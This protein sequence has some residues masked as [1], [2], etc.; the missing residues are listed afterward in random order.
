MRMDFSRRVE[1]SEE[2]EIEEKELFFDLDFYDRGCK[3]GWGYNEYSDEFYEMKSEVDKLKEENV[4]MLNITCNIVETLFQ[5]R[6]RKLQRFCHPKFLLE[7]HIRFAHQ[8][9]I[10]CHVLSFSKVQIGQVPKFDRHD[11]PDVSH[12][13]QALYYGEGITII[14]PFNSND[15]PNLLKKCLEDADGFVLDASQ[16]NMKCFVWFNGRNETEMELKDV[17]TLMKKLKVGE[18]HKRE[19][20]PYAKCRKV[21]GSWNPP[22]IEGADCLSNFLTGLFACCQKLEIKL[23]KKSS[24]AALGVFNPE[25]LVEVASQLANAKKSFE[26]ADKTNYGELYRV[27]KRLFFAYQVYLRFMFKNKLKIDEGRFLPEFD[28]NK[29]SEDLIEW[30]PLEVRGKWDSCVEKADSSSVSADVVKL[31]AKFFIIPD[32]K[33]GVAF[34]DDDVGDA[35]ASSVI[36]PNLLNQADK[37]PFGFVNMKDAVSSEGIQGSILKMQCPRKC[38]PTLQV[39][40]CEKCGQF[41]HISSNCGGSVLLC[42]CGKKDYDK[43][44]FNCLTRKHIKYEIRGSPQSNGNSGQ[45]QFKSNSTI[46]ESDASGQSSGDDFEMIRKS[47]EEIPSSENVEGETTEKSDESSSAIW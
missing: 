42:G 3:I 15:N 39:W 44:L 36:T 34:G 35:T 8:N 24:M 12:Y 38:S 33:N 5:L 7:P 27:M 21:S 11:L 16:K 17:F 9:F 19:L 1:V 32:W 20:V 4:K 22:I 31:I 13:V 18:A 30:F 41:I 2:V 26:A 47:E 14:L 43:E 45:K 28:F 40:F 46:D 6:P 25:S 23:K 29:L 10:Y 37:L